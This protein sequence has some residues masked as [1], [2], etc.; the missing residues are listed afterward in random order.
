MR[1]HI[2]VTTLV[3]VTAAVAWAGDCLHRSRV[4]NY[5]YLPAYEY[6]DAGQRPT[7]PRSEVSLPMV[8]ITIPATAN[9]APFKGRTYQLSKSMLAI[10][11]CNISLVTL[12]IFDNGDWIAHFRATQDVNSVADE[13]Q[14]P[15]FMIYR[16]NRF[17]VAFRGESAAEVEQSAETAVVAPPEFFKLTLDPFW[18]ERGETNVVRLQ[19]NSGEISRFYSQISRVE[20]DL[21]YE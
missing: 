17:H 19:G 11:H 10:D 1:K 18:V 4:R 7:N 21:Q 14:R 12:T 3:A 15:R 8:E 6:R 9:T 20:V 5:C 16:R 13:T 2:T